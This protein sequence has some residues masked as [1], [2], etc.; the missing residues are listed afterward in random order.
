M[1]LWILVPKTV[2]LNIERIAS[3]LRPTAEEFIFPLNASKRVEMAM[4]TAN[5]I[6]SDDC[7][8]LN[9]GPQWTFL[10][11]DIPS[12]SQ[13]LAPNSPPIHSANLVGS[14]RKPWCDVRYAYVRYS[15]PGS[16]L[17]S[18]IGGHSWRDGIQRIN[19]NRAGFKR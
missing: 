17:S 16:K 15:S 11:R 9:N 19:S 2:A 8:Q 7:V 5:E 13:R 18:Y 6:A 14:H 3:C 12:S 10:V 1:Y 4:W